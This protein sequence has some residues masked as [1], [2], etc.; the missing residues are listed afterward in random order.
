MLGAGRGGLWAGRP[1]SICPGGWSYSDSG[2][3]RRRCEHPPPAFWGELGSAS[4]AETNG[5]F[6]GWCGRPCPLLR[7]TAGGGLLRHQGARRDPGRGWERGASP[8]PLRLVEL[9]PPR[10]RRPRIPT[11]PR[12]RAG[13]ALAMHPGSPL[14]R[15][16]HRGPTP[17]QTRSKPHP[18]LALGSG[19]PGLCSFPIHAH[20][21]VMLP[22]WGEIRGL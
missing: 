10:A 4:L 1:R 15:W 16:E 6:T 12:G 2:P 20:S 11:V 5:A 22:G 13:R 19:A 21:P 14:H 18:P 9:R 17:S 7:G 8:S 3:E